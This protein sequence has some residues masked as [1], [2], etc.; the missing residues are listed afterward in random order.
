MTTLSSEGRREPSAEVRRTL[1]NFYWESKM[2]GLRL[3][4]AMLR[5]PEAEDCAPNLTRLVADEAHHLWLLSKNIAELGGTPMPDGRAHRTRR[6]QMAR[7]PKDWAG[8]LALAAAAKKRTYSRYTQ[9]CSSEGRKLAEPW[10]TIAEDD[11]SNL[12]WLEE[13]LAFFG[14]KPDWRD[15]VEDYLAAE[16]TMYAAF[17]AAP[18]GP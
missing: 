7:V 3:A 17:T 6:S 18:P 12:A 9:E 8:Q 14:G 13:K 16:E 1:L 5:Q 15:R 11:R 2:Q 4:F 10:G